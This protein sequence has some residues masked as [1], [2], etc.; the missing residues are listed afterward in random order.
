MSAGL[1]D[2]RYK[3]ISG[4]GYGKGSDLY[5]SRSLRWTRE[6]VVDCYKVM[7]PEVRVLAKLHRFQ[8]LFNE[9]EK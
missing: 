6:K 4:P 2:I 1:G 8:S 9:Q 3:K 7:N 5:G